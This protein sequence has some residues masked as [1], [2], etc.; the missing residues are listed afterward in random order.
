MCIKDRL[1]PLGNGIIRRLCSMIKEKYQEKLN[2]WFDEGLDNSLIDPLFNHLKYRPAFKGLIDCVRSKEL[3]FDKN[4]D[5]DISEYYIVQEMDDYR[6][7]VCQYLQFF[8]LYYLRF[9]L[10]GSAEIKK[11]SYYDEVKSFISFVNEEIHFFET[12]YE[13]MKSKLIDVPLRQAF[14]RKYLG[15][16][17]NYS[18]VS[19]HSS[20]NDF[21]ASFEDSFV[22]LLNII[23]N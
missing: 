18:F 11:S 23:N 1:D 13:P 12:W 15:R 19:V 10:H 20:V 5:V 2:Y 7:T 8:R 22:R 6:N 9:V 14:T 4:Y 3:Y 16:L 17:K 21:K